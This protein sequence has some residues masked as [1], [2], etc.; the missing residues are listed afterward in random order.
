MLLAGVF[1]QEFVGTREGSDTRIPWAHL[2]IAG[3]ANNSGG[4]LRVT[5]ARGPTGVAVRT[6]VRLGEQLAAGSKVIWARTSPIRLP[7]RRA[8]GSPCR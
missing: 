7:R 3:P 8:A 4:G 5:P 6:L 1:L 2:D